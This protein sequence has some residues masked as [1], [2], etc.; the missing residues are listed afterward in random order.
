[1]EV[2][3][4]LLYIDTN[5]KMYTKK[6]FEITLLKYIERMVLHVNNYIAIC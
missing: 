6:S 1:M 3:H 5:F 2:K 4:I